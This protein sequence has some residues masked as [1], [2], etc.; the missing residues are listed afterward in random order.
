M[1]TILQLHVVRT[2]VLGDTTCLARNHVGI[3]DVVEKRCLT[4]VHVT[5]D[6]YDWAAFGDILFVDNLIGIDFLNH[7]G[8][9]ELSGE[10]KL[11]GYEVDGF[12]IQTLV[13]TNHDAKHHT[14]TNDLGHRHVH[15]HGKVVG[16]H[17]LG[18][19]EYLALLLL[20]SAFLRHLLAL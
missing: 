5:H 6:G 14:G 16:G 3:T 18:E 17:K 8:R 7:F 4:V 11:L 12:C 19:F 15:H 2:D 9:N 20:R 13:D 1:L 10:A